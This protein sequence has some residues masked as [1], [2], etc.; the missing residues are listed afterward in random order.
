LR[1]DLYVIHVLAIRLS[2][3]PARCSQRARHV[4]VQG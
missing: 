3:N 2:G 4:W 1:D